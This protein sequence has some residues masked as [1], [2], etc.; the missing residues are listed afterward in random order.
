MSFSRSYNFFSSSDA[1][2]IRYP[3]LDY[4]LNVGSEVLLLSHDNPSYYPSE[5]YVLWTF[6]YNSGVEN[7]D[8]YYHFSFAYIRIHTNDFLK[9]GF[10]WDPTNTTQLIYSYENYFSGYPSDV[11]VLPQNIFVE[12]D[13]NPPN[14]YSGFQLN[15]AV[16]N[17]SGNYTR[18]HVR[19]VHFQDL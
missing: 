15:I 4:P 3:F 9:V 17:I 12:F 7:G 14:E 6:S 2:S 1:F 10:G 18:F 16:R 11:F 19:W 13:A 5:A 8:I